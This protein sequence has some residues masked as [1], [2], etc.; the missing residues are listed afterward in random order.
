MAEPKALVITG[1]GLNCEEETAYAFELAGA[2]PDQIHLNDILH[3]EKTILDYQI[4]SFIGGFSFGDHISAG[5]VQAV[6]FKYALQEDLQKF[7]EK[8]TLV[9]GI[10]NGFQ[11]MVKLGMLPGFDRDYRTQKVTLTINNSGN[12]GDRWVNLKLNPYSNS[13]FTRGI[14]NLFLP[15][16]H[17]EGKF[18]TQDPSVIDRLAKNNQVVAQYTN[19]EGAP[20]QK[21]P[22][23]PNGSLEAIAAITDPTGKILGMM[24]HPEAYLSPYNHPTWTRLK[25][26]GKLPKEG[27][28][29]QIFRNAVNYFK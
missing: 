24:P 28:G 5:I 6:K 7:I 15:V 21:Y 25:I 9:I 3:K 1:F 23:N 20:T 22:Q 10:C 27:E 16:R 12:F 4:L 2:Q 13:V 14:E 18:F 29:I 19:S 8:D 11:T 26:D 17:G